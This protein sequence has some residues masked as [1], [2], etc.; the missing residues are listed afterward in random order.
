L[1]RLEHTSWLNGPWGMTQAPSDFGANSH[2]V[3]VGQ[4]GGGNILAFD[5]ATGHFK[6]PLFGTDNKPVWIDGVWDIAFGSGTT[7]GPATS[8]FFTAGLDGEQHGLFGTLTAVENV[9]GGD[10]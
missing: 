3:L 1:Q 6:G 7:S 5:A 8:L 4:F 10:Q 9:L 2:D